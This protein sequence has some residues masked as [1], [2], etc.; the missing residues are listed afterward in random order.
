[1]GFL[2][3]ETVLAIHI[4]MRVPGG[5]DMGQIAVVHRHAFV[6]ELLHHCCH[7]DRVPDN[8]GIGHKI[9]T[10]RLMGQSLSPPLAELSL[11]RDDEGRP[12]VMQGLAF[13]ELA[14]EAGKDTF[15][16][17]FQEALRNEQD[18]LDKVQAWLA[19]GQGRT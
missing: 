10:Q 8:D 15:V 2:D 6:L 11:I 18:H 1:M 5:P 12:Q 16:Q 13:I 14:Q 19:A 3:V 17:Q 7:V 4:D 9:Q